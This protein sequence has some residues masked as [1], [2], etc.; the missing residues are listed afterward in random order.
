LGSDLVMRV[1]TLS[2][3]QFIDGFKIWWHYWEVME[4][5][6][7]DLIEGNR[8]L[9]EC[10][11][12]IYLVSGPFPHSFCFLTALRWV[13][14]LYHACPSAMMLLPCLMPKPAQEP[15]HHGLK[16]LTLWAKIFLL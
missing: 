1:L 14:F 16:P 8:L 9:G 2:M 4:T 11:G 15:A 3:D 10:P 7:W 13:A 12:R 6:R 5:R